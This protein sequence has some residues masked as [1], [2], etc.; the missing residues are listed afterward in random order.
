MGDYPKK[1]IDIEFDESLFTKTDDE[2]V[3]LLLHVV[4]KVK[5]IILYPKPEIGDASLE[6]IEPPYNLLFVFH[7]KPYQG[8]KKGA[9]GQYEAITIEPSIAER[10]YYGACSD[11]WEDFERD[12]I[13][14]HTLKGFLTL[15]DSDTIQEKF[16]GL[17]SDNPK[18]Q[19]YLSE[20][21]TVN[22]TPV[23]LEALSPINIKSLVTEVENKDSKASQNK[24][25]SYD[26]RVKWVCETYAR[27]FEIKDVPKSLREVAS[28]LADNLID[29]DDTIRTEAET[30]M[31][32][33][34][35]VMKSK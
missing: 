7:N 13:T 8:R 27:D 31:R 24:R 9:N 20:Y 25:E 3:Y 30:W 2:T 22:K 35:N 10:F 12:N 16:L 32:L 29:N 11:V 14:G 17:E 5:G 15:S 6:M 28:G 26:D 19:M 33:L 34:E 23:A 18:K 4:E 21:I 1:A